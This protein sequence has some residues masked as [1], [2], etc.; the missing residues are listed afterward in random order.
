MITRRPL[1]VM[2]MMGV[3]Q[4]TDAT[5]LIGG[6]G[7]PAMHSFAHVQQSSIIILMQLLLSIG[8]GRIE[9]H[10]IVLQ[11]DSVEQILL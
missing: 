8:R 7:T 1:V 5:I 9:K 3:V 4:R 2:V 10:L 6:S 11:L